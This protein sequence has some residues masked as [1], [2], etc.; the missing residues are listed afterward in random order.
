MNLHLKSGLGS[1]NINC[2]TMQL[3]ILSERIFTTKFIFKTILFLYFV[4]LCVKADKS[5][6]FGCSRPIK[7]LVTN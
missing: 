1:L 3:L 5:L 6:Q 2:T 7:T 4:I